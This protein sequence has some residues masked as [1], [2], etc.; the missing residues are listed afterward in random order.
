[1]VLAMSDDL[2][3]DARWLVGAIARG[4]H[5]HG[6]IPV[7]DVLQRLAEQDLT[8]RDFVEPRAQNIS[9]TRYFAQ[10]IA[11]TMMLEPELAAAIASLDGHLK[12]LQS[13]S[14]TAEILGA[15][16]LENYGWCEIIGPQGFFSGDDFLLGLLMLGPDCH[17]KDHYHPAP[18]L[19]WPLTGPTY[20]K[21]GQ[22]TFELKAPGD[23]IW[24][25]PDVLHATKTA[26]QPMLAVW[27][28]T[29]DT[30]TPAKLVE[31]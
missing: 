3:N 17:Y 19:Y 14:N 29:K 16:F 9:V 5:A 31:A 27:S 7:D 26:S 10:S 24:H 15:N 22:G 2:Y 30:H 23:I 18:E 6:G 20:W 28:W 1:M 8:R 11:E 25:A 4:L 12:W 13:K 21:Q